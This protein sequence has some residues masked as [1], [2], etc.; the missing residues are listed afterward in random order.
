MLNIT[1]EWDTGFKAELIVSNVSDSP[2]E[3]WQFSFDSNFTVSDI[4]N[5]RLLEDTNGRY[6]VASEAWINPIQPGSSVTIGIVGIK[7]EG[8]APEISYA[9]GLSVEEVRVNF[10]IKDEYLENTLGTYSDCEELSGIKRLNIF[11]Y[12][13]E[14]NILLP[15]E[16]KFDI[17][18]NMVYTDVDMVGTYCL[19]DIEK[20][21]ENIGVDFESEAD[22]VET[23]S[24]LQTMS[25]DE[26][27]MLND[28][29]DNR[30]YAQPYVTR[31]WFSKR[32][33]R[34][35]ILRKYRNME[36]GR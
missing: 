33:S 19:I 26:M 25:F 32:I 1:E 31:M 11:R 16:T 4:W 8:K 30:F 13:E 6:T 21:F 24:E 3:A 5:C 15:I 29:G 28:N 10:E 36:S 35:R 7:E 20:W 23:Y 22:S 17:E 34:Y 9:S 14:E 2:L 27:Q 12:F 18:N